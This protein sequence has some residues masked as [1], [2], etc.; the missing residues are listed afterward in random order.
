ME[1]I[2]IR[3]LSEE[4]LQYWVGKNNLPRY[5]FIQINEWLWKIGARSFSEMS[6]LPLTLREKLENEFFIDNITIFKILESKDRT[7]KVIMMLY[8]K[9]SYIEGVLIPQK[10]RITACLSVQL[11]CP[12][13]CNFCMSGKMHFIRNLTT[14]EIFQQALELNFLSEKKFN[15]KI[16]NIV[17]MG[18]GEPLLN[19]NNL[20]CSIEKIKINKFLNIAYDKITISTVGIPNKLKLLVEKGIKVKIAWSLHSPFDYVREKLIPLARYFKIND[21]IPYFRKLS[22]IKPVTIEYVMIKDVNDTPK[23]LRELLRIISKFNCKVNL[24]PY[25]KIKDLP[26]EPSSFNRIEYF[27]NELSKKNFIVKIRK[28]RGADINGACGQLVYQNIN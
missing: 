18:M 5:R 2:N 21:L 4:E 9:K 10:G 28:S 1:K 15:S 16:T 27:Y 20:L 22:E 8:D 25:N 19:L 13:R 12:V 23:D 11:G 24:I 3:S 14:G 17:F 7:I 26:F 6:N